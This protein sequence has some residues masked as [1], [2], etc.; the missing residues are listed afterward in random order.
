[1]NFDRAL[2]DL[3]DSVSNSTGGVQIFVSRTSSLI[4]DRTFSIRAGGTGH[5][6]ECFRALGL[7]QLQ[8]ADTLF[9]F[10][11]HALSFEHV[12]LSYFM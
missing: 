10:H 5:T 12:V 9:I 11:P 4:L 3:R 2:L 6:Q 7:H 8:F 1:M